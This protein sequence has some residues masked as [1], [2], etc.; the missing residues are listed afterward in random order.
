VPTFIA[1]KNAP[2]SDLTRFAAISGYAWQ[3][4]RPILFANR[5]NDQLKRALR[6]SHAAIPTPSLLALP[7]GHWQGDL[8]WTF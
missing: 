2:D 5:N 8:A 1:G 6:L 3:I 4:A 7:G